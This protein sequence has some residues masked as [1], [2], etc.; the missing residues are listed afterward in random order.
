MHGVAIVLIVFR[1]I[2]AALGGDRVSAPRTI[3]EH[4]TFH[5]VTQLRQRGSR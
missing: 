2:D 1:A 3:L 5:A 4:K